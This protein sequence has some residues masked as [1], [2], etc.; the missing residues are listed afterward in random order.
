MKFRFGGKSKAYVKIKLKKNSSVAVVFLTTKS[1]KFMREKSTQN[2]PVRA[3]L[4][5]SFQS[6]KAFPD[7]CRVLDAKHE[8]H[9]YFFKKDVAELQDDF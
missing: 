3:W 1:G 8:V 6:L 5:V 9:A 2:A 4:C 7:A